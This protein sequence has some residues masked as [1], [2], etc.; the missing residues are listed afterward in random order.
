[1]TTTAKRIIGSL[2]KMP[3]QTANSLSGRVDAELNVV[4]NVLAS[5]IKD[6]DIMEVNT[7]T[8]A[9]GAVITYRL[10]HS[11]LGWKSVEVLPEHGQDDP[12]HAPAHYTT[13]GIEVIDILRAKLTPEEFRGFLKGNVIKYTLRA[14]HKN[15]AQDYQKGEWYAQRLA[16]ATTAS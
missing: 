9:G 14:E 15:G 3:N 5:L 7:P 2:R 10:A 11:D 1:M 4:I 13:G 8:S 16:K 12:V 6:G